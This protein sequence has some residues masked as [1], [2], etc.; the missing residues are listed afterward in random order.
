M[1]YIFIF[2]IGFGMTITGGVTIIAYLN[3]LAA[4]VSWVDYLIFIGGRV[5]CYFFPI[6]IILIMFVLSRFPS[7]PK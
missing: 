4:G 1:G 2:L 5:E 7:N 6:G 3:I